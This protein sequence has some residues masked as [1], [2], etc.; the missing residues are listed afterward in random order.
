MQRILLTFAS[1]A[2]FTPI[3]YIQPMNMR[4][5]GCLFL[6]M[7]MLALASCEKSYERP[8]VILGGG[9]PG[10]G[11]GATGSLLATMVIASGGVTA[12]YNFDYNSSNQLVDVNYKGEIST[13]TI[14]YSWHFNR[15][16]SGKMT[17]YVL[18]NNIPG[19]PTAGI[20]YTAHYPSGSS[21]WDYLR[22]DYDFNGL[23]T[24]DS[25]VFTVVGGLTTTL[26]SYG[27]YAGSG[28][29]AVN[30]TLLT[31]NNGN[32]ASLEQY[33]DAGSGLAKS[34]RN[35]YEY[36]AKTNPIILA[37][38]GL[39]LGPA[40]FFSKNNIAKETSYDYTATP[41]T[42]SVAVYAYQYNTANKPVSA[43]ATDPSGQSTPATVTYTYK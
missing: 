14:T 1:L 10:G 19:F 2:P 21:T 38:E 24:K 30:K 13:Q 4:T 39:I 40:Q 15:D 27:D 35:E 11:S 7:L 16:A 9:S 32:I 3:S 25:I 37:Q 36:D 6:C 26:T 29:Q 31:Y 28:Y 34:Q 43:K 18:K 23:A 42:Q 17:S 41:S 8:D 22:G 5:L 12:S 33:E 20:T